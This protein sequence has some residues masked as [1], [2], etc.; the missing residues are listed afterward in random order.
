MLCSMV[1]RSKSTKFKSLAQ[2]ALFSVKIVVAL[3]PFEWCRLCD[4]FGGTGSGPLQQTND[5][6]MPCPDS[7]TNADQNNHKVDH[8]ERAPHCFIEGRRYRSDFHFRK[9]PPSL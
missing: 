9:H 2:S 5:G 3:H 4:F 8:Q 7:P 1:S 6:N